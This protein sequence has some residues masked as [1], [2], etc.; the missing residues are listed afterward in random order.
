MSVAISSLFLLLPDETSVWR[1]LALNSGLDK[2]FTQN[3]LPGEKPLSTKALAL[4]N[5]LSCI[6]GHYLK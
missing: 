5:D 6:C 4:I 3:S 1:V 2:N